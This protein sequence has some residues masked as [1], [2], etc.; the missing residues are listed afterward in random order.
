[1]SNSSYV[2]IGI[3]VCAAAILFGIVSAIVAFVRDRWPRSYYKPEPVEPL[4]EP[5]PLQWTVA[6]GAPAD[7]KLDTKLRV[8]MVERLAMIGEPW[9]AD[10]LRAA[11]NEDQDP[12]VDAAISAA[13]ARFGN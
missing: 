7:T 10:A 9:C 5:E 3:V 6:L 11:A 2:T 4:P 1:M 13:L 8:E 12:E